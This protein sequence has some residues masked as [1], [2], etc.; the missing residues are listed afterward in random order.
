MAKENPGGHLQNP[1]FSSRKLDGTG[2]LAIARHIQA[3]IDPDGISLVY[4]QP[5]PTVNAEASASD[6]RDSLSAGARARLQQL[7]GEA[8]VPPET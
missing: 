2:R 4:H 7:W 8:L 5:P 3:W 6:V 1:Q